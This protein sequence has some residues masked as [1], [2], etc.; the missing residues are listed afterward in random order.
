MNIAKKSLS[1]IL[2]PLIIFICISISSTK[3]V[4]AESVIT[5][6]V[7]QQMNS[8][9]ISL[10]NTGTNLIILGNSGEHTLVTEKLYMDNKYVSTFDSDMEGNYAFT[11]DLSLG[12]HNYQI[13]SVDGC[14]TTKES[15]IV[16]LNHQSGFNGIIEIVKN[17]FFKEIKTLNSPINA[18][19]KIFTNFSSLFI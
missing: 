10:S 16:N 11:T 12:N 15:S 3:L 8:P 5:V 2:L 13:V 19:S 7:C 4:R 9:T 17:T 14:G 6:S 1:L 18:T